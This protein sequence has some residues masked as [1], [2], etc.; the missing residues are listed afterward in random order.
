MHASSKT[1]HKPS[2][3]PWETLKI[4]PEIIQ[5]Y[6]EPDSLI[7]I[8]MR[9]LLGDHGQILLEESQTRI[10][11]SQKRMDV[12]VILESMK[13]S[14]RNKERLDWEF[15]S[16]QLKL[17]IEQLEITQFESIYDKLAF[18]LRKEQRIFRNIAA[19]ETQKQTSFSVGE[20][21]VPAYDKYPTKKL[22]QSQDNEE[23]KPKTIHLSLPS[24]RLFENIMD[25]IEAEE[26]QVEL[27]KITRDLPER[28]KSQPTSALDK[29]TG[30][31][32]NLPCKQIPDN[33]GYIEPEDAYFTNSYN[34]EQK[35]LHFHDETEKFHHMGQKRN[36]P[37]TY[38]E[39]SID[40]SQVGNW[41]PLYDNHLGPWPSE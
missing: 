39:F 2:F 28:K 3:A 19:I 16:Q 11:T 40:P 34:L 41:E 14:S 22:Q 38:A 37:R 20:K 24:A 8:N 10:D 35:Q 5:L 15:Y 23:S 18:L 33:F 32:L 13:V 31:A 9:E 6:Q 7:D 26:A 17:W 30:T 29:L 25:V 36:N 12:M 1:P 27:E 4:I 21:A